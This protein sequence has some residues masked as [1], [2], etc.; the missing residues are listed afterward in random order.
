MLLKFCLMIGDEIK[1]MNSA[2]L[3]L[4]LL[5]MLDLQSLAVTISRMKDERG[6]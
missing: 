5:L 1:E 4:S 2:V 6:E 3:L